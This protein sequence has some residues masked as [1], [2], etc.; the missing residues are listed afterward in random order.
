MP[1]SITLSPEMER[2]AAGLMIAAPMIVFVCF[3]FSLLDKKI[4]NGGQ[5]GR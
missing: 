5:D 3:V 4:H 1:I 2:L